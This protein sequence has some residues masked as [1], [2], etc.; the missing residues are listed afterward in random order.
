M[1]LS[2]WTQAKLNQEDE[3]FPLVS[4]TASELTESMYVIGDEPENMSVSE[5]PEPDH[6]SQQSNT[7]RRHHQ[8]HSQE[9]GGAAA[10]QIMDGGT[11]D[12]DD[13]DIQI[14]D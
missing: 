2:I 11:I 9:N 10:S 3:D 4:S 13:D 7:H 1:P 14:F 5:A 8:A 12:D 6:N